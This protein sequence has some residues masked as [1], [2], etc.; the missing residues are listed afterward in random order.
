MFTDTLCTEMKFI[1]AKL[2]TSTLSTVKTTI[3]EVLGLYTIPEEKRVGLVTH[4]YKDPAKQC[5]M[6]ETE[7]DWTALKNDFFQ[8]LEEAV[9]AQTITMSKPKAKKK[10]VVNPFVT[11]KP[12]TETEHPVDT[13]GLNAT[14]S[15]AYQARL[16]Q[17]LATWSCD[18]HHYVY[19]KS[20]IDPLLESQMVDN[21]TAT[22]RCKNW[23]GGEDEMSSASGVRILS[24]NTELWSNEWAATRESRIP[25]RTDACMSLSYPTTSSVWA[26]VE[27][28]RRV[29]IDIHGAG[30]RK[31]RAPQCFPATDETQW[32]REPPTLV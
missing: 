14:K 26:R 6:L 3:L 22:R 15:K 5:F 20:N 12:P 17:L 19:I 27:E 18:Q 25:L 10:E 11:P 1:I 31:A 13:C 29:Y 21:P 4:F 8:F 32:H 16:K 28:Q 7:E 30:P 23:N 9:R 24:E 2:P